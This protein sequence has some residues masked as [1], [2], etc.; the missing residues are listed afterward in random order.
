[1]NAERELNTKKENVLRK[2]GLE[3]VVRQFVRS[4]ATS[5]SQALRESL[6]TFLSK[7]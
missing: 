6:R 2:W 4:I 7:K 3:S 5:L 1:M